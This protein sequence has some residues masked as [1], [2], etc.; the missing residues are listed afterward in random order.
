MPLIHDILE[1]MDGATWFSTL[2][3]Q[4]GYWQVDLEEESKE[5]TAFITNQGL[6]QSRSMPAQKCCIPF[7]R[8]MEKVLAN[9]VARPTCID[10][11]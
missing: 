9:S 11:A 10:A 4:S 1:S 7:Q 5:K 6:F 8:L 2:D 3:L